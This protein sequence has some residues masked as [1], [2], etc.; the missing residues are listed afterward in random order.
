[1]PRTA[2]ALTLLDLTPDAGAEA[3]SAW[4]A[5]RK[6]PAYR[7]R[8]LLPR[9]WQRPVGSWQEATELPAPLRAE[10][11]RDFPLPR[12]A[13]ETVQHSADGTRKYLWRLHDGELIESVLIPSGA[14]RT[15]C[16]SSQAGCALGC[17]FCA[18]GQMGFAR[19]LTPGEIVTQALQVE[20]YTQQH[21]GERVRNL[22]L[23]GMGEPLHNFEAV[24]HALDI[25]T[26]TRGL[27]IGP[28]RVART[29]TMNT[30]IT[31]STSVNPR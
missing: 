26:D 7:V 1:M 10:L 17:V 23:M 21:H 5:E 29:P 12:L 2:T 3:L 19:H 30:T 8:Q 22:V 16:I 11:D 31:I 24:M 15:L 25:I 14:R 27:N 18:T 4:A 13:R 20:R 28:A 9:L 6:L